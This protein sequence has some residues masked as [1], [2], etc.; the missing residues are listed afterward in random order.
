MEPVAHKIVT[1]VL[2]HESSS[3]TKRRRTYKTMEVMDGGPM[4]SIPM[5][6]IRR[7]DRVD[8]DRVIVGHV[9]AQCAGLSELLSLE[10]IS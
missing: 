6:D 8:R 5:I 10:D 3:A 1:Q 7:T 9:E 4:M 2:R